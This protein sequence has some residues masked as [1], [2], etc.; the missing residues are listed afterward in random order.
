M[1]YI[2]IALVAGFLAGFAMKATMSTVNPSN[3]ASYYVIDESIKY[4]VKED[5]Y[6]YSRT[7]SRKKE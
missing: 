1:L 7:T 6:L 2:I 4:T 5:N 3:N